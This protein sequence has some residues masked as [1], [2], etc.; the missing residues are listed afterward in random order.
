MRVM[1]RHAAPGYGLEFIMFRRCLD[2]QRRVKLLQH[3]AVRLKHQAKELLDIVSHQIDF[4]SVI[5]ARFL[6]RLIHLGHAHD[7]S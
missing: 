7:V 3:V 4:H 6:D 2:D 1:L 5:N